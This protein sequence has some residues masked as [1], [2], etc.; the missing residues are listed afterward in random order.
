MR[1]RVRPAITNPKNATPSPPPILLLPR[2]TVGTGT[3]RSPLPGLAARALPLSYGAVLPPSGRTRTCDHVVNSEGPDPFTTVA[4]IQL[5]GNMRT[6]GQPRHRKALR[7]GPASRRPSRGC[8]HG[9]MHA[10]AGFQAR[11]QR[12]E[13]FVLFTTGN[14]VSGEQAMRPWALQKTKESAPS[15]P[16]IR[17]ILLL[18][19]GRE[20]PWGGNKNP[21]G[22]LAREGFGIEPFRVRPSGLAASSRLGMQEI[23]CERDSGRISFLVPIDP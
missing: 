9:T 20:T 7:P 15:P 5:P 12:C 1:G 21:S 14:L 22:A 6:R 18:S 10:P 2:G 16:E 11:V 8:L 13:A 4:A 23:A 17:E 19:P 3:P